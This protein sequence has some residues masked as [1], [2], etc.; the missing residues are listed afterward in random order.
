MEAPSE[1]RVKKLQRFDKET[2]ERTHYFR[3]EQDG[4]PTLKDMVAAESYPYPY[5]YPYP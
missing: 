4:G 1:K 3:D 5:P 2:G